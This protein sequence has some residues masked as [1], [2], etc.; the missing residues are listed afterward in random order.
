MTKMGMK[1]DPNAKPYKLKRSRLRKEGKRERKQRAWNKWALD[2]NVG[3]MYRLYST[4]FCQLRLGPCAGRLVTEHT[5]EWRA[6][7]KDLTTTQVACWSCNQSKGSREMDGRSEE[8]KLE[9]RLEAEKQ[10]MR[11]M[12]VV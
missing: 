3:I 7:K 9:Q 11:E 8:F 5:K 4:A 10:R 12:D 6:T 2:V 1:R